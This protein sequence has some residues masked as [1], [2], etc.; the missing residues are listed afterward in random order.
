MNTNFLVVKYGHA[1]LINGEF[2]LVILHI[3]LKAR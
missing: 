2:T 1:R 3:L